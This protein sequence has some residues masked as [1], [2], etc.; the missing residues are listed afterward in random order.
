[1]C[2]I[3]KKVT[4][5]DSEVLEIYKK[6]KKIHENKKG[7]ISSILSIFSKNKKF[8][9]NIQIIDEC[10]S[11]LKQICKKRD[12]KTSSSS[13]KNP[14]IKELQ[15]QIADKR[16][17]NKVQNEEN[18]IKRLQ[19]RLSKPSS[20]SETNPGIKEFQKINKVDQ[21]NRNGF[22][23]PQSSSSSETNSRI[24]EL[25]NLNTEERT[26]LLEN[27]ENRVSTLKSGTNKDRFINSIF[28]VPESQQNA[29]KTKYQLNEFI[30]KNSDMF[31]IKGPN[32]KPLQIHKTPK[33]ISSRK[34]WSLGK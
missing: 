11:L 1:M 28:G 18:R 20:S 7:I 4:I 30:N 33:T 22:K 3:K 15:N 32:G 17:R 21:N 19:N 9:S 27:N 34:I 12:N 2:K 13:E 8:N 16:Q 26:D 10:I 5:S 24:K 25:P 31:Q 29:E 6:I 14:R 23:R